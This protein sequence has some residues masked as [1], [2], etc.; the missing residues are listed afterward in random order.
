MTQIREFS[1]MLYKLALQ[2]PDARSKRYYLRR[3]DELQAQADQV[4][5]EVE[6]RNLL[7]MAEKEI[8]D[9]KKHGGVVA[10]VLPPEARP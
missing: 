9:A 5:A 2:M 4:S 3:G 10:I 8:T 1:T 6:L 7:V